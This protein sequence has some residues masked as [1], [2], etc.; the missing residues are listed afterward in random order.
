MILGN[1]ITNNSQD[2]IHS[3]N[4][5][6]NWTELELAYVMSIEMTWGEKF[7]MIRMVG[8]C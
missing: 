1:K 5:Q 6:L 3:N 4:V 2:A 8:N 7:R